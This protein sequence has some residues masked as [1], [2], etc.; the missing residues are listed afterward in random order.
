VY[1]SFYDEQKQSWSM[2]FRSVEE[3]NKFA[4]YIAIARASYTDFKQ[5]ITQDILIGTKS[6]DK[7]VSMHR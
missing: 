7:K 3:I 5:L 1:G 2:L 4:T 6:K